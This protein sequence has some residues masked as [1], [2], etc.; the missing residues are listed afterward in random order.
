MYDQL[1]TRLATLLGRPRPLKP[2]TERQLAQHLEAHS[3]TLPNF[4]LCASAVLEEHE[5]ALP[6]GPIF[7]PT[8]DERAQLT[9]L[10]FHW[11]PT[12]EQIRQLV[13]ELGQAVPNALVRL[14]DGTDAKLTLHEV[15][16]ERFVRLLRLDHGPDP[17]TAAAMRD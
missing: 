9:D 7:T 5:L 16:I 14:P 8:L 17:A 2:Q 6:C 15:M 11:R 12:A 3:S 1:K 10:L 4:F 13:D